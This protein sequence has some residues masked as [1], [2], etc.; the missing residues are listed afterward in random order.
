MLGYSTDA[1]LGSSSGH[2]QES[3]RGWSETWC[4]YF[5]LGDVSPTSKDH[6]TYGVHRIH[7][8]K[9]KKFFLYWHWWKL[10]CMH[11]YCKW[12]GFDTGKSIII[13]FEYHNPSN[14]ELSIFMSAQSNKVS[15]P[16]VLLLYFLYFFFRI[17][18]T[19]CFL[20]LQEIRDKKSI[21]FISLDLM[22]KMRFN[23][24]YCTEQ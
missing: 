19:S 9:G 2:A 10:K 5:Q 20:F 4:W 11:F 12:N 21:W 15:Q 17:F 24:I 14:S 23:Y 8:I 13:L 22:H 7:W 1:R 3:V 16:L 18:Q 6:K